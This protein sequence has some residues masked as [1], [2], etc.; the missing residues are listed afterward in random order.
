MVPSDPNLSTM[1]R[2]FAGEADWIALSDA[3]FSGSGVTLSASDTKLPQTGLVHTGL[4]V[5]E[6][7]LPLAGAMVLLN[8]QSDQ[9]WPRTFA[10]FHDLAAGLVI[11]HRQGKSVVR[12]VLPGPIPQGRCTGRL[13]FRFDAPARIWEMSFE[14]LGSDP[15]ASVS[16]SGRNPF[17]FH[18]ADVK[19]I[20]SA[21]RADGP[22]LWFGLTR[23]AAP[24][25]RAPWIGQR[26]PV[27]TSLGPVPAGNLVPGTIIMT[28]DHG[29]LPLLARHN[30]TLPAR[31]S[32]APILLRAPFFGLR[33]DLLVS[34]DQLVAVTGAEAEYLF[35]EESVLMRAGDMVD[36]RTALTDQR[37]AV[38]ESVALDLGRPALIE[39][40]G[41]L[42]ATGHHAGA[43]ASL[44]CLHSYEVLTLMA[45]LGRTARRSA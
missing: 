27:E 24:P 2:S 44:R 15:P 3:R 12:H 20:C 28:A 18:L 30:L 23:G 35:A 10:V 40:D 21:Q 31:G 5:M 22:V 8:H 32:F 14:V 4:F 26:T 45:L 25:A 41:C 38:I 42:I 6:L 43:E 33:Q 16:S 34:A 17:P 9:G 7:A 13:S 36:G 39:A 37:R 11:L 19:E 1:P 29:P